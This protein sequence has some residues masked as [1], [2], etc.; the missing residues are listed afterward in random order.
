MKILNAAYNYTAAR[1]AHRA[2]NI[3][4]AAIDS[5]A[6]GNYY[7]SNYKGENHNPLAPVVT[8]GC[9]NDAAIKLTARDTIRFKKLPPKAKI[10]HKFDN[11]TT[12]LLSVSQLCQENMTVTFDKEGV[13]MNNNEGETVIRGHL[14]LGNN[15]Y[16]VPADDTYTPP[17]T[18]NTPTT[19]RKIV[20]ISQHRTSIA[21]S[22]KCVPKFIKYLHAASGF[23]VKEM[24]IAVI[25]KG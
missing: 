12:P 11:I 4:W 19:T 15:L 18:T 22:I 20:E 16:M 5:G 17:V 25:V 14:D 10:C 13:L 9:A 21:Y 23:P 1:Q 24:L 2:A 8:V 6:S 3:R 7:P